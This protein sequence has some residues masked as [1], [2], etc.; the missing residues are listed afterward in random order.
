VVP[1]AVIRWPTI[2][3]AYW[4]GIRRDDD[5]DR[6]EREEELL[7]RAAVQPGADARR[8]AREDRGEDQQRDAVA[9]PALG[10]QLAHPHQER[11]AGRQ[12]QD[13]QHEPAR[14]Q[15]QVRLPLEQVGVA[16]RLRR[17]EPDGEVTG[18]LVD[19]GGA[20]LAFLLQLLE[21][22]DDDGQELQDDR[23]RHVRH[24]PEREDREL[25]ERAA[26]EQVQQRE[27]GAALAVEV[28][29]DR[30][31]VDARRRHP[32]AE[33]VERQDQRGEEDAAAELGHPPRICQPGQHA[34]M[35]FAL[36]AKG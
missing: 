8:G 21:L 15:L 18:V 10:D 2:R 22:R 9:D 6:D 1:P 7:H 28:V 24:D 19:L 33:P 17:R 11:R 20:R 35:P 34:V 12:R 5:A 36:S 3:F 26:R 23:R 31:G 14:V 25:R 30:L 16:R 29:G 4:I 32:R 13:D 27:D